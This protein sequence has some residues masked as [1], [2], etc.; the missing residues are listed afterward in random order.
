MLVAVLRQQN[1]DYLRDSTA[2]APL[3]L[4]PPKPHGGSEH[5]RPRCHYVLTL[6]GRL[7]C[8]FELKGAPQICVTD[9]TQSPY[10]EWSLKWI[11]PSS[12]NSYSPHNLEPSNSLPSWISTTRIFPLM[13]TL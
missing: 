7:P 12:E 9:E 6:G 2:F 13:V 3:S 10:K 5:I 1:R 4:L 8:Q 11:V